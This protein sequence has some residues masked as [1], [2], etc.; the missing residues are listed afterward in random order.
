M[1]LTPKNKTNKQNSIENT[2]AEQQLFKDLG[3]DPGTLITKRLENLSTAVWARSS[4]T[5]VSYFDFSFPY[6]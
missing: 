2:R 4:A 1:L 6:L 5:Q 3:K